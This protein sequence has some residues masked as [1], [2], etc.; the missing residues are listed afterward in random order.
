MNWEKI[1][2]TI[3]EYVTIEQVPDNPN[4]LILTMSDE[5]A[6]AYKIFKKHGSGKK[7]TG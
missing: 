4:K 1:L 3:E 5:L 2:S 7:I 6:L